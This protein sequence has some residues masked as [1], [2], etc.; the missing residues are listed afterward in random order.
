VL[1]QKNQNF[2][3]FIA[4][5][6]LPQGKIFNNPKINFLKADF[7]VP[8]N[9]DEQMQDKGKKRRML[10]AAMH[11]HGDGYFMLLDSDDLV[12]NNLAEYVLND[13]NR[14]GYVIKDG[15]KLNKSTMRFQKIDGYFNHTCGSSTIFYFK[16]EDLPPHSNDPHT[17][18]CDKFQN[19]TTFMQDSID[20]GRPL[21]L[22]PF[23]AG[24]Y[25]V[26]NGENHS[27]L[28]GNVKTQTSSAFK[29]M[30]RRWINSSLPPRR[31]S[32]VRKEFS[33]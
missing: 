31:M 2:K 27:I 19:H 22:I 30:I 20:L 25:V 8:K 21:D 4:C 15:Y 26:D 10:E 14:R 24:I 1:A 16:R 18:F 12:S 28:S 23:P 6:D 9:Y 32:H 29:N 13:N 33:V 11:E 17:Y 7:P 3:I 5:H